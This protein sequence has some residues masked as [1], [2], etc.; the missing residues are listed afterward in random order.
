MFALRALRHPVRARLLQMTFAASMLVLL[1]FTG[2]FDHP[3]LTPADRSSYT[4]HG[5]KI[6]I[7]STHWNNEHVLKSH[8]N[9]AIIDLI[10]HLGSENV[11]I[12]LFES[13]S[14]DNSKDAL[15]ELDRRLGDLNVN[16]TII[17][18]ETTHLDEIQKTTSDGVGWVHTPRGQHELRRIPFLSRLR[19]K[20]LEPLRKLV[21][22]GQRFDKI[23]FV[24]DVVFSVSA[25]PSQLHRGFTL[26]VGSA[27]SV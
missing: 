23:M 20:T 1:H 18:D 19:N 22:A 25:D 5:Q 3:R 15:R 11:Y 9:Q 24:N 17:L 4:S 27:V 12:S 14:W 21:A 6:F 7:S 26:G 13:G 2:L 10:Y 16:R 8:W